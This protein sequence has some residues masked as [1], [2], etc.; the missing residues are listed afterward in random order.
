MPSL[1]F[2]FSVAAGVAAACSLAL[3]QSSAIGYPGGTA[4]S[5]G[6]NPIHSFSGTVAGGESAAIFTALAEQDFV[7][8]DV[9]LQATSLDVDCMDMV[10][11]Q[12]SSEAGDVAGYDLS[13]RYCYGS[14]CDSEGRDVSQTLASGLRLEAGQSLTIS[15]SIY[16]S[17]TYSGCGSWRE[18]SVR[19]TVAGY[20]AQR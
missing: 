8:T 4:V 6:S 16:N 12:L 19:Y 7:I 9:S 10:D 11:V 18:T 17:Y 3:F 5:L 15:T 2:K 14:R 20:H 13:T 1:P